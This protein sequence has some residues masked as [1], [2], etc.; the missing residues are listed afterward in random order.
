MCVFV[1][2]YLGI[3]KCM[4]VQEHVYAVVCECVCISV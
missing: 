1:C 3:F 2:E 4:R